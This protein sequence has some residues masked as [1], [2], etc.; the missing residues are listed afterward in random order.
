MEHFDQRRVG[1]HVH[2]LSDVVTWDRVQRPA[3]LDVEPA[4]YRPLS[5][6]GG[7]HIRSPDRR[8]PIDSDLDPIISGHDL[9][10]SSQ[11]RSYAFSPTS[12]NFL[13]GFAGLPTDSVVPAIRML[14]AILTAP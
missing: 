3:D 2:E 14:C 4:D 12:R 11:H 8:A 5:A 10:V 7:L 6:N 13:L 1:P 9:R